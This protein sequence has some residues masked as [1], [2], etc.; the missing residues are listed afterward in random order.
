MYQ[1]PAGCG[2]QLQL[3]WSLPRSLALSFC[4]AIRKR[5][6]RFRKEVSISLWAGWVCSFRFVPGVDEIRDRVRA[7]RR[8]VLRLRRGTAAE[9]QS[10][11]QEEGD[12]STK[13]LCLSVFSCV[14]VQSTQNYA[15]AVIFALKTTARSRLFRP[16]PLRCRRSWATTFSRIYLENRLRLAG[17]SPAGRQG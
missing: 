5:F 15:E 14:L 1:S 4:Q 10:A 2:S 6:E 17:F 11:N 16:A 3:G 7:R 13:H 8:A 12:A 9:R